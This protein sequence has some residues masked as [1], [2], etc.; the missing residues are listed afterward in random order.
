[1]QARFAR[2]FKIVVDVENT[3]DWSRDRAPR[4]EIISHSLVAVHTMLAVDDGVFV[5]LLDPPEDARA[6]VA[7]CVNDGICALIQIV[8]PPRDHWSRFYI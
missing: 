8:R 1:M 7:G 6:V 5:S 3:T 2:R 4:D